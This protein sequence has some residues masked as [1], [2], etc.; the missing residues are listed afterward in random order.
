MNCIV[1]TQWEDDLHVLPPMIEGMERELIGITGA[2]Y[3]LTDPLSKI[4][5]QYAAVVIDTRPCFS[6]MTE[7][8]LLASAVYIS[9]SLDSP[10]HCINS[11]SQSLYDGR[12]L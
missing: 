9:E 4:T 12:L 10:S 2:P 6:L 1:P 7:M 11:T 5:G 3:R 8:G